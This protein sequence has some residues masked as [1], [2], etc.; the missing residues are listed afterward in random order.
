MTNL[1]NLFLELAEN[2]FRER[3]ETVALQVI[4]ERD[5]KLLLVGSLDE[6]EVRL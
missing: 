6:T 3:V 5:T 1:N 4:E 2:R